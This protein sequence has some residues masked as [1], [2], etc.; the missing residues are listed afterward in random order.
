MLFSVYILGWIA[1]LVRI[2]SLLDQDQDLYAWMDQKVKEELA[3]FESG[4][5]RRM[6]DQTMKH[7]HLYQLYRIQRGKVVEGPSSTAV[8]QMLES[9]LEV[10]EIPD[11]EFLYLESDGVIRVEPE[12]KELVKDRDFHPEVAPGPVF[13]SAKPRNCPQALLFLDWYCHFDTS[14]SSW[15]Q[16]CRTIEEISTHCPWEAKLPILFWRG[17]PTGFQYPYHTNRWRQAPRAFLCLLS[18]EY[19][20]QIQAGFYNRDLPIF[21]IANREGVELHKPWAN[22]EEHLRYKYQIAID[23]HTCTYPG[24][25]WRLLS[26]ALL[27][28]QETENEQ[29]FYSALHPWVHYVPVQHDLSDLLERIEWARNHDAEARQIAE[30][31]QKWARTHLTPDAIAFYCY[32]LLVAYAKLFRGEDH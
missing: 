15:C 29:W 24:L 23:G 2:Q 6:L 8:R 16:L 18:H 30:E 14:P 28:L 9:M 5:D 26:N 11:L 17:Y 7:T 12:W 25:Q 27:F 13:V 20:E 32:K 4:I 22:H 21:Q 31:G 19:P 3:Y 1:S 10:Y